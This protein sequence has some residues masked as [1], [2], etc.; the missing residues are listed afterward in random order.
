MH[1][2]T[3]PDARTLSATRSIAGSGP[4]REFPFSHI[5]DAEMKI[6]EEIAAHAPAGAKGRVHFTTMRNRVR[7]GAA[8]LEPIPACSGCN[9]ATF[10]LAGG[11]P[12][13][14]IVT[15]AATHPTGSL[16]TGGGASSHESPDQASGATH[17]QVPKV[18]TEPPAE[19]PS[20]PQPS[21]TPEVA[22]P[23]GMAITP[24]PSPTPGSV[25][26]SAPRPVTTPALRPVS[27]WRAGLK[28]G[29]ETLAWILLF[30]GLEWY[31]HKRLAEDL[32]QSIEMSRKGSLPWAHQVKAQAPSKPVYLTIIVRSEE[33]SQYI[34]L[35]GWMPVSPR[36]FLAGIEVSDRNVDPP[37]VVVE[38]HS[39]DML[40]P[41]K[42]TTVT[43]S[44][45]VIP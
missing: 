14:E 33:Y 12:S 21:P 42:T 37:S 44:E 30:A 10:E 20:A 35:L 9:R 3:S 5:N 45:L 18:V 13:V 43:Y 38:D 28:A 24:K 31:A 23:P 19:V 25:I 11:L 7:A 1:H 27:P 36:L 16:V 29:G 15:H 41:G 22:P 2:A 32:E 39:L 8:T 26:E 17:E 40:R 4:R 34:P 6:F